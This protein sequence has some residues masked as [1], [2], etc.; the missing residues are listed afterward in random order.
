MS[1]GLGDEN[2]YR[3]ALKP[4]VYS[5][6]SMSDSVRRVKLRVNVAHAL[7]EAQLILSNFN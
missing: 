6:S 1:C 2:T 3:I 5:K 7:S 4:T